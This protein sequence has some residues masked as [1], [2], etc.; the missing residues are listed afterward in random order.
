MDAE[1]WI[2]PRKESVKENLEE[3][4]WEK[5][6]RSNNGEWRVS[7]EEPNNTERSTRL[8]MREKT[9]GFCDRELIAAF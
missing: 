7:E 8:R 5:E 3:K 4:L 6:R 1:P 9:N 2:T